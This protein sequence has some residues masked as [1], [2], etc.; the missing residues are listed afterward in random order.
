MSLAARMPGRVLRFINWMNRSCS[1]SKRV[2]QA[3]EVERQ[4]FWMPD[5]PDRCARSRSTRRRPRS[6]RRQMLSRRRV[7]LK[8]ASDSRAAEDVDV[9][10]T[11]FV[12]AARR[13]VVILTTCEMSL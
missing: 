3:L 2:H 11:L 12:V 8:A 1:S 10:P 7:I 13:V 4:P 9:V 6:A 5:M